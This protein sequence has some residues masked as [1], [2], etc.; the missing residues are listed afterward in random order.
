MMSSPF[1]ARATG[2]PTALLRTTTATAPASWALNVFVD[3]AQKFRN[4]TTT[5]PSSDP[6]GSGLQKCSAV[7]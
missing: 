2:A 6:S 7:F 5:S 3:C 1:V 4:T